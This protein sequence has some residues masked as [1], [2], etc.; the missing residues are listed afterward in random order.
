MSFLT[1]SSSTG[2]ICNSKVW[3]SI[4]LPLIVIRYFI[5]G[6][7]VT[8]MFSIGQFD[9]AG[10]SVILAAVTYS[11]TSRENKKAGKHHEKA[12]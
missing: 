12:Q 10:A 8:D 11:Y 7:E 4:I 3:F 9:S 1:H 6:I 5:S 2:K